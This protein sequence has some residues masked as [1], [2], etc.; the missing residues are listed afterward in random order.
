MKGTGSALPV[1]LEGPETRA[2]FRDYNGTGH[3]GSLDKD[4]DS[5]YK[6]SNSKLEEPQRKLSAVGDSLQNVSVSISESLNWRRACGPTVVTLSFSINE[7]Q[8]LTTCCCLSTHG[9]SGR[10][11]L[12]LLALKRPVY[13][14]TLTSTDVLGSDNRQDQ[15]VF[16]VLEGCSDS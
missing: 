15:L 2:F 14:C 8:K 9:C 7:V 1:W 13:N 10:Y 12:Q 16:A 4:Q 11:C 3:A 5:K 6:S